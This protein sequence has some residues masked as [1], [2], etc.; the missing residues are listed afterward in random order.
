MAKIVILVGTES[1]N[2]Q[3]VADVL[4]DEIETHGHD[5]SVTDRA[6]SAAD[7]SDHEIA[8][9]V[10]ATHGNGDIPTNI[11][12]LVQN[13]EKNQPDL[14]VLRYGV[15]ALGD[16]TYADTFCFGGK[17][18]DAAFAA[19]GARRIGERLEIDATSQPFPDEEALQ[20]VKNWVTL[21]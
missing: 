7:V 4:K 15:I 11:L 5:V 20:W 6:E 9:V 21:L 14:S 13:L 16:Q 18:L 8:L 19:R 17:K 2:A 1:G 3:M 10:C 12:G